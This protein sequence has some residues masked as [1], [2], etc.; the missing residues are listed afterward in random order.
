MEIYPALRSSASGAAGDLTEAK[1][2]FR[3]ASNQTSWSINDVNSY[4]ISF[5]AVEAL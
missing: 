2:A 1:G 4:G 3:L 5:G